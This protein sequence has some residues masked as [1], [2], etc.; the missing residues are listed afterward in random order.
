MKFDIILTS[1]NRLEYLKRTVASLI[2]SGAFEAAERVIIVDN[3]STEEGVHAF[4]EDLRRERG[5]FLVLLPHNRGWGTAVNDA[6]GLSRAPYL[7]VSNNDVDYSTVGFHETMLKIFENQPNIGILGVW[8]HTGHGLVRNGVQTELF[9]EMD[10]V[11]AV[12]WMMPKVA[13][14]KVGML[15]EHGPC[16]TKGGNGEDTSYVNRM[17]EAGFLVGVPKQDIAIHIDGY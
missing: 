3:G 11:P 10:N 4:L 8:R 5:A 13:M 15:P 12:G 17:K 16:F 7:F 2:S 14:E 9:N 1:W 6:L